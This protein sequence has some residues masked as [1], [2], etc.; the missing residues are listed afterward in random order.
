MPSYGLSLPETSMHQSSSQSF[1]EN[2]KRNDS[3]DT[4]VGWYT[5]SSGAPCEL[6]AIF[7]LRL[8]AEEERII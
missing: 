4:V 7:L 3:H 5:T 6:I 1:L 2:I 8:G